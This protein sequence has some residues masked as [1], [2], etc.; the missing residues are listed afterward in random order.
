MT[1]EEA[2]KATAALR[3]SAI[4]SFAGLGG[5]ISSA[6]ERATFGEGVE[7]VAEELSSLASADAASMDLAAK[8]FVNLEGAR[9][10]LVGDGEVLRSALADIGEGSVIQVDVEGRPIGEPAGDADDDEGGDDAGDDDES[11]GQ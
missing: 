2:R 4:E 10:L 1:E 3:Q 11:G 6:A 8:S 5:V 9:W 7:R